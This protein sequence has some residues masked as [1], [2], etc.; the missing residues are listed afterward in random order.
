MKNYYNKMSSESFITA[1]NGN[2]SILQE[3]WDCHA[4]SFR[5]ISQDGNIKN[6]LVA[7]ANL[8]K[9]ILKAGKKGRDIL[10]ELNSRYSEDLRRFQDIIIPWVIPN[11]GAGEPTAL[12]TEDGNYMDL[13][14]TGGYTRSADGIHFAPVQSI[15]FRQA[16]T[17]YQNI[18]CLN[19][20]RHDGYVYCTSV[21]SDL[22]FLL[23]RSSDNINFDFV[24]VLF[25][26]TLGINNIGNTFLFEENGKWYLIYEAGGQA[27]YTGTYQ[28]YIAQSDTLT[29][30]YTNIKDAPVIA[31]YEYD[32]V[33]NPELAMV[34]NKV[35]KYNG[36]YYMYYH[37]HNVSPGH[38]IYR[39]R[40]K[41]LFDW[42]IEGPMLD[43]RIPTENPAWSNGDQSLCE[44]KGHTYLFYTNN[45]NA[46]ITGDD[47]HL[48][49]IDV[50]VDF[51]SLSEIL[52]LKP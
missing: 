11:Q 7:N 27:G 39:A 49:H 31:E 29:G 52:K 17:N 16:T 25:I 44:F 40:S 18:W 37:Y 51:R 12:V 6:P 23:W 46:Y 22:I 36:Y 42:E 43:S 15:N 35:Y 4:N 30:T 13:W 3:K 19:F 33:G 28:I 14:Y 1:L 9:D 24:Q 48:T 8:R 20:F 26:P 34:G 45:A 41:N 10:T 38:A 5:N 21:C 2:N 50:C 47:G 32:G